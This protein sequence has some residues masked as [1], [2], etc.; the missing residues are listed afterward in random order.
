[1]YRFPPLLALALCLVTLPMDG[2]GNFVKLAAGPTYVVG[3]RARAVAVGDFN[4]DGLNDIAVAGFGSGV[5][6]VMIACTSGANC[7]NGFLPAVNYA[8]GSP[9][10]VVAADVNGDGKLDLVAVSAS[11]N[12]VSLFLGRGDGTFATSKCNGSGGNSVFHRQGGGSPGSGQLYRK[13]QRS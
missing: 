13:G 2:A 3:K 10:S 9:I 7:V 4:G 11:G 12:S 5:V 8:I 1:M 6:N